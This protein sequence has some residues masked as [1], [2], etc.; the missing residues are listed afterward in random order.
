MATYLQQNLHF[1]P[2]QQSMVKK[3]FEQVLKDIGAKKAPN[4]GQQC[5]QLKKDVIFYSVRNTKTGVTLVYKIYEEEEFFEEK[6]QKVRTR[7]NDK[8]K[9][10]FPPQKEASEQLSLRSD[11]IAEYTIGE[12]VDNGGSFLQK[13]QW[14]WAVFGCG[15][16][17]FLILLYTGAFSSLAKPRSDSPSYYYGTWVSSNNIIEVTF[18][19]DMTAKCKV[20]LGREPVEYN[21]TWAVSEGNG[22][23]WGTYYGRGEYNFM[24]PQGH[25]YHYN[26]YDDSYKDEEVSLHKK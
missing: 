12:D 13:N 3:S 16:L 8:V 1:H 10:S 9:E 2:C 22:V 23:F 7:I 26:K 24:T 20:L 19:G 25:L 14:I 18:V 15:V 11:K 4:Y 6:A 21:T 17:L 5:W